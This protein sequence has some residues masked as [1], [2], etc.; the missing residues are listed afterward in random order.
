MISA[1]ATLAA[2]AAENLGKSSHALPKLAE[3]TGY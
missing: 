2:L 3:F 1:Q